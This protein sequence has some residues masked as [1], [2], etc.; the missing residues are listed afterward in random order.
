MKLCVLANLFW[1]LTLDETLA[2]LKPLGVQAVEIGAGGFPGKAQ[3]NPAELLADEKNCRRGR[4]HLKNTILSWR[5]WLVMAIRCIPT[6][7]Q[8]QTLIGLSG[9]LC[10]WRKR[11]AVIPL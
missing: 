2:K 7:I 1:D 10:C 8:P 4:K 11:W 9:R 5:P 3:C 6:R